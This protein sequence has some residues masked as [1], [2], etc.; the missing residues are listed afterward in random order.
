[1]Q[2]L[3]VKHQPTSSSPAVVESKQSIDSSPT[4]ERKQ[5][6]DN[7]NNSHTT[8]NNN[9]QRNN[10]NPYDDVPVGGSR[11]SQQHLPQHSQQQPQQ[12]QQPQRGDRRSN[13][14]MQPTV[15]TPTML[16]QYLS[17]DYYQYPI[18]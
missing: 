12:Q 8:H 3:P 15:C 5:H 14:K 17:M 13:W 11:S 7:S 18:E 9:N 1:M 4:I 2:L 6:Q 16:Y 10:I